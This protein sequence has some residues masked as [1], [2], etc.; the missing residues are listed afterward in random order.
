MP[1]PWSTTCERALA[2]VLACAVAT[3]VLALAL[4]LDRPAVAEAGARADTE[5]FDAVHITHRRMVFRPA[6]MSPKSVRAARVVLRLPAKRISQRVEVRSVRRALRGDSPL[7]VR[8][9]TL[10]ARGR[11]TRIAPEAATSAKQAKDGGT[12]Q[13]KVKGKGSAGPL[14]DEPAAGDGTDAGTEPDPAPAPGGSSGEGI[15]PGTGAVVAE[16]LATEANPCL[17][18]GA[19]HSPYMHGCDTD[20]ASD[21]YLTRRSGDGD[22][23]RPIGASGPSPSYRRYVSRAGVQ[24]VYDEQVAQNEATRTQ[25]QK[26]STASNPMSF[27]P[28]RY[29]FYLSF[30]LQSPSPFPHAQANGGGIAKYSQLLQ[31]K[32]FGGGLSTH[33]PFYATIGRDGVKF[34]ARSGDTVVQDIVRL[35]P[36][37][38]IRMA[39]VADWDQSGWYEVWGDLD[40]SGEMRPLVARRTGIDFMQGRSASAMGIGLYH[41]LS[42]FDGS[43]SG[44]PRQETVYTD[45]ANVQI[46][47]YE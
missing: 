31:F 37:R 28:G 14:P 24:S 34:I 3:P 13:L 38:W 16:D 8:R 7:T 6:G 17:V 44:Q 4:S 1:R 18:W 29:A 2:P 35:E 25:T 43:V 40:G 10:R 15:V 41:R 20:G 42:L 12:G 30:R 27:R 45:Y 36:G 9:A 33:I 5:A 26:W 19:I 11:V 21:P 47:R 22:P 39:V 46:T 32:S 23:H